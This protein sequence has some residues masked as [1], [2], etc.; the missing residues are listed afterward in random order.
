MI[1]LDPNVTTRFCLEDD[2][3]KPEAE[4]PQLVTRFLTSDQRGRVRAVLDGLTG[5]LDTDANVATLIAA[6]TPP[7]GGIVGA[8]NVP[9]EWHG[10]D[11]LRELMTGIELYECGWAMLNAVSLGELDRKKSASPSPSP[12][13]EVSGESKPS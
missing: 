6:L 9:I 4:R 12:T 2:K 5:Q 13:P 8:V 11:T 3:S 10:P 7:I 1:A